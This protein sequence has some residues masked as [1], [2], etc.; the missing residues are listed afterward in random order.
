MAGDT[1][2]LT[3]RGGK[4]WYAVLAVP[5]PLQRVVGK[6]HL[7]RSL[8]TDDIH[9]ARAKRYAALAE[10]HETL[11]RARRPQQ[12]RGA[13]EAAMAWRETFSAIDAGELRGFDDGRAPDFDPQRWARFAA[14]VALETEADAIEAEQGR[15]AVAD[16]IGIANGTATPL[17]LHLD[18]WLAEG[19]AKGPLNPRTAAQYRADLRGLEA[20]LLQRGTTTLEAVTKALAGRW[21]T[22]TM[23]AKG[24]HWATS[25]RRITA[26][27][28]YWRWLGK[29]G[30]TDVNPWAG[31][32][33]AKGGA[34]HRTGERSKR[35]FTNAEVAA[36]LAGN[37]GEELADAMRVAALSGM[38]LE[39]VYR[40][41]VTDCAGGWFDI[42]VAKS[43]AGRR[44]VPIHPDLAAIVARRSRGAAAGAFLFH[45]AG[46]A[47]AGR[48]RSAILSKAFG[49]YRQVV[50]VHDRAEGARHSRVDFHSWRRWFI[51]QA[52]NAGVD[53]ATVAAVIG[54]T[55]QDMT[56]GT[57]R[58]DVAEPL[59]RACVAAVRL[60]APGAA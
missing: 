30:L 24:E 9:V 46:P 23:V 27:G 1:K 19:G 39:E 38:R 20:W 49:R 45:E 48:E 56:D 51:T 6:A 3:R 17:L 42:R 32:S 14:G 58:G 22:E 7:L 12:R 26:A 25:N 29:R 10:F 33:R 54:H 53:R 50:G 57:Y 4:A 8:G 37:P 40:L 35:P 21:I 55:A 52:R 16:F 43:A 28:S 5:R 31:Q 2:H 47:R 18:A 36:L 44:R 13:I 34:A 11:D 60:P 41:T 15:A 59:L